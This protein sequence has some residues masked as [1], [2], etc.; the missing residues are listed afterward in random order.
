MTAD[1]VFVASRSQEC[2]QALMVVSE[3]A[4][5]TVAWAAGIAQ[6]LIVIRLLL[7]ETMGWHADVALRSLVSLSALV[8]L[9]AFGKLSMGA[10][11]AR[12]GIAVAAF[13]GA[14]MLTLILYGALLTWWW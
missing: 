9:V 2:Y 10:W 11:T 8:L 5:G 14:F 3:R 12:D 1:C 7:G 13:T 4:R 6:G